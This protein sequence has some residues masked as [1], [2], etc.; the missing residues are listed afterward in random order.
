[1]ELYDLLSGKREDAAPFDGKPLRILELFAGLGGGSSAFHA[2][3]HEVVTTDFDP[4]FGC[5]VTGDILDDATVD[6]LVALGP[7][8]FV[9]ASPPCEAFTVMNIGKNWNTDHTPRY[10]ISPEKWALIPESKRARALVVQKQ[11]GDAAT[12]GLK[13]LERTVE[14]LTSGVFGPDAAFIIENPRGKMR[15][16]PVMQQFQVDTVWYCRYA[17]HSADGVLPIAKPTDLWC[18]DGLRDFWTPRPPC[19]NGNPDHQEARRG[20][21]AGVQGLDTPELRA[22]V[23]FELSEEVCLAVEAMKGA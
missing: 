8:D 1:M 5:D 16:M 9:W 23:P 20:A 17:A 14:L 13:I 7:F 3:G 12:L 15:K 10:E 18:S 19:H 2:R 21:K 11:R 4:Q 22:L 6:K